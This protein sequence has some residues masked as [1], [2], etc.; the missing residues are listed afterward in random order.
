MVAA[1]AWGQSEV[2]P[3]KP[4]DRSSPRAA[5]KTFLDAT[6]TV[7]AYLATDY[8]PSPSRAKFQH[9][10]ELSVPAVEALDLSGLPPAARVK[11]SRSAALS[12]FE[13]LSRIK[14]PPFEQIPDAIQLAPSPGN[15]VGPV[16]GSV[17]RWVI[18]DTEIAL[19]RVQSGPRAGEY[20]FSAE[21]VANAEKFYERVRDLPYTRPVPIEGAKELVVSGGGSMIPPGWV[22]AMP[23]WLRIPLADQALWKWVGFVLV[24]AIFVVFLDL[25]N[26]VSQLGRDRNPLLNA[27]A[28]L[29]MPLALLVATPV[30]AYLSL[31]QLNLIDEVG[32]AVGVAATVIMFLA[33][34]WLSWRFA[35]V[36]AEA[37]ISSPRIGPESIDAHM[38]R[39]GARLLAIFGSA[40]LLAL[41][42]DR[43]GV[44]VYGIVAGLGVGGLAIALA[45]QPTIENLIGGLNLFADKPI[46]VG[47]VCRYGTDI[48]TVEAIGIRSTRIR[49][50]DRTLTTIPNA[51]LA[52]MPIVNLT[53]RDRMLIQTVV[54][55]RYETTTEQ[56]RYVL[57]RLR[58]LLLGHPRIDPEV[59]RA[60][61]V[62]FGESSLDIEVFAY[63]TTSD[64]AEFLGI[65]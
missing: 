37:I 64:W 39:V 34:A 23:A 51:A 42:A 9:L 8:L 21:T 40:A 15:G 31:V 60:R 22:R 20:L 48:G 55:L 7:A 47:E 54:G 10:I 36:V 3:L 17:P 41:G 6:D 46:R 61:L 4:P 49:A 45:A 43:L 13:V 28:E 56:L 5:L 58:E 12:L 35:P 1:V 19:V 33:G 29:A 53:R 44:P 24:L 26:R 27:L 62:R 2:N 25:A 14:L 11:G 57:V 32:I 38:I 30:A 52:K 65:R 16:G 50:P 59:A 18:P 63:V